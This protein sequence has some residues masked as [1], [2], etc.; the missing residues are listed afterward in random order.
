MNLS[1]LG[2]TNAEEEPRDLGPMIVR[3]IAE[4]GDS[5]SVVREFYEESS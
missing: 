2:G 5:G 1:A 4:M 3:I